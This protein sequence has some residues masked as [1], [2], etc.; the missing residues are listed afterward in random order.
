MIDGFAQGAFPWFTKFNATI[1][2]SRWVPPIVDAFLLHERLDSVLSRLPIRAEVAI[3]DPTQTD[4]YLSP[5]QRRDHAA[6][7][8]GT[9]QA[10]VEAR[11]PFEYLADQILSAETLAPFRVLVLPNAECLGD[12]QCA[13]IT[14]WVESGGSIVVANESSLRNEQGMPRMNFGLAG[15]LGVD[16]TAPARGPVKNNYIALTGESPVH[17]G[18]EG[19]SRIIGGT[20]LL[21]IRA[22]DGVDVP[23]RFIPDFPDLP[24]EEVYPRQGPDAPAVTLREVP[25]GGRAAYVAFNIGAIFWEALQADHGQVLANLVRWA[26]RDDVQV[27]IEGQ[28]LLDVAVRESGAEIAV[29]LVNLSNPMAMRGAIRETIPIGPQRVQVRVPDGVSGAMARLLVAES[30]VS[31]SVNEGIATVE[32]PSIEILEVVHLTWI[33]G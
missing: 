10:L 28:G 6:H 14:A 24:M 9:C 15:V 3:L 26:L 4:R 17:T 5:D 11:I 16:L 29:A 7:E 8:D 27:R 18:L 20:A 21:G 25:G 30:D 13:A 33:A 22:R 32:V 1:S 23:F 2:D 31:V 12:D 19:A